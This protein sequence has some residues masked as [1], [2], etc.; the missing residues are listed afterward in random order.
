MEIELIYENDEFFVD[1]RIIAKG[2]EIEH[3]NLC[4]G[5]QKEFSG[6]K[7]LYFYGKDIGGRPQRYYLLNR[8]QVMFIPAICR[9]T[10]RTKAFQKQLIA[11]FLEME[12]NLQNQEFKAKNLAIPSRK[13]LAEMV[14]EAEAEIE[15]L[16]IEGAFNKDF[17]E[18][19]LGK[20]TST[21]MRD[22]WREC[23]NLYPT[24]KLSKFVS[25]LIKKAFITHSDGYNHGYV[26]SY[27]GTKIGII[28][29]TEIYKDGK[30]IDRKQYSVRFT[31]KAKLEILKMLSKENESE[32]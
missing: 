31:E 11:K 13:Q 21:C 5:I 32:G 17:V 7:P 27:K 6:L 19:S 18:A 20:E 16:Q 3:K 14:L 22:L 29:H 26:P 28:T 1:S 9:P 25:F 12:K 15:R 30:G 10:D 23:K 2:F 4:E 8:E 24:L